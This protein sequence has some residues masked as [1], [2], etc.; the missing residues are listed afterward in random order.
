VDTAT[1]PVSDQDAKTAQ[2]KSKISLFHR[3]LARRNHFQLLGV[4]LDADPE[5]L[6]AN[7]H[8]LAKRWHADA[9]VGLDLGTDK[10][11]LDEIFQRISE[12]YDIL[13]DA[14][15][16]AEYLVLVDR[17]SKG[18]ATDV[19][20]V[21]RAEQLMDEA[22]IQI[23]KREWQTARTSLE[24]AI[25][26]N[27]DDQLF[28]ANLAWVKFHTEKKTNEN[29]KA[30]VDALKATIAKQEN[31]AISYQ[32]LGSIFFSLEK[33]DDARRWWKKC[34]EW[35]PNNVEAGRGLRLAAT[36][37]EQKKKRPGLLGL[38]DKLLGKG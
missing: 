19:H 14:K 27:P 24:E 12:A 4:E 16:R 34:L 37:A 2:A 33:F 13:T 3:E 20:S 1:P 30:V 29:L 10:A 28:H 6:K 21:L 38:V 5:K 15:K 9:Y 17:Q 18:L 32:Y 22:L 7:Y 31:I 11:K 23:R 8:A 25:K 26:L 35:E 36:R